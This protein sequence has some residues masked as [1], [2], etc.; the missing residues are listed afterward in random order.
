MY[1]ELY[2]GTVATVQMSAKYARITEGFMENCET[3]ESYWEESYSVGEQNI[4]L[5]FWKAQNV[6]RSDD[7]PL[8]F[9]L[10][11]CRKMVLKVGCSAS[12]KTSEQVANNVG[13]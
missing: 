9:V 4:Y 2:Q 7:E 8:P 11:I 5:C 12:F 6:R 3:G 1:V 10:W 13:L